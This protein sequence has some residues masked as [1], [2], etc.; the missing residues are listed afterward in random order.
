MQQC[1]L[2]VDHLLHSRERQFSVEE[3]DLIQE[4][5]S[6]CIW[7][8]VKVLGFKFELRTKH[9]PTCFLT[10][11]HRFRDWKPF[12]LNSFGSYQGSFQERKKTLKTKKVFVSLCFSLKVIAQRS[13][14]WQLNYF[15]LNLRYFLKVMIQFVYCLWC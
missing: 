11:G 10:W 12:K 2:N 13:T 4:C 1:F 8:S 5:P 7:I 15:E 14:Q 3:Y 6:A 9:M